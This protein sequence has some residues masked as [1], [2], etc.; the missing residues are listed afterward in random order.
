MQVLTSSEGGNLDE[1]TLL[2][3][4]CDASLSGMRIEL[5]REIPLHSLVDLWATFE[6]MDE[7][8]YLR[9]HVCWCYEMGGDSDLFQVGIELDDAFATDYARWVELMQSFNEEFSLPLS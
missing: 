9:G 5:E 1:R 7:K 2:C 4:S 3:R 8:Y 6:G